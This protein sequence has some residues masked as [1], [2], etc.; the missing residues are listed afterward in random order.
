MNQP[1]ETIWKN[2]FIKDNAL[3]APKLNGLYEKKSIHLI[4][5]FNKM[6][7][8]NLVLITAFSLLPLLWGYLTDSIITGVMIFL[9]LNWLVVVGIKEMKSLKEIDL[10]KNS[11]QYLK[12]FNDW[13]KQ[14]IAVYTRVYTIFYPLFFLSFVF[15]F[16]FSKERDATLADILGKVPE[17]YT[18]FGMPIFIVAIIVFIT[19]LLAYFGGALYRFDLNIVYGRVLKRLDEIVDD[20]EELRAE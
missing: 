1:I 17:S 14:K 12:A 8:I 15:G 13:M 19:G 5:K 20:L 3:V 18:L 2:A 7:K 11:Y 10:N 9:L 16:W 4:D 6:F